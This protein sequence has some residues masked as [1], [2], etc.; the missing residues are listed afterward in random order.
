MQY[1]I[2]ELQRALSHAQYQPSSPISE[3]L[4]SSD[5]KDSQSTTPPIEIALR[6][7]FK[8][9]DKVPCL[10]IDCS[11]KRKKFAKKTN[12]NRHYHARK[13]NTGNKAPTG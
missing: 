2:T 6:G 7:S 13:Y 1:L 10:Y 4:E 11:F 5:D 8:K 3:R 12:L 9:D